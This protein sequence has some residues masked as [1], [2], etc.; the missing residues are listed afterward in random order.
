MLTR[1]WVARAAS[2]SRAVAAAVV[3]TDCSSASGADIR[4]SFFVAGP[5]LVLFAAEEFEF[6]ATAIPAGRAM[7]DCPTGRRDRMRFLDMILV[8]VEGLLDDRGVDGVLH[9][10][11]R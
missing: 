11:I 6:L 3:G 7:K 1:R 8:L 4:R 10:G 5:S 9:V 2:W